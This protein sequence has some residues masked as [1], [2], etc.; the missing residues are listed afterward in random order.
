MATRTSTAPSNGPND[1]VLPQKKRAR[2][3]VVGAV[4]LALVA[5]IVLPLILDSE[6]RQVR[7]DVQV[8][9]PSRDT[10]LTERVDTAGRPPADAGDARAVSPADSA[11]ASIPPS[12]SA[13]PPS[14]PAT[15][16]A[17]A[18]GAAGASTASPASGAGALAAAAV[19]GGA[20]AVGASKAASASKT[21]STS[22]A[23]PAP[24]AESVPKAE[25]ASKAEAAPK[26][27]PAPKSES[28]PKPAATESKAAKVGG[29]HL[30]VGAFASEKAAQDQ[31]ERVRKIGGKSYT[32]RIKTQQGDRIR[33]RV[34]PYPTRE[35]A[36]QARAR[37]RAAGVE[38]AMVPHP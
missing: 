3:R 19:T 18:P 24:N 33:V 8:R 13:A 34:G 29:Y 22:K 10:P 12:D 28:T 38:A 37:L 2:R 31:A 9:I 27:E 35:A 7:D 30:Q 21:E 25:P 23:E 20:A 26:A 17:V 11:T 32:E 1:P 15:A 5:A 16:E 6:P 4:A 36:D 14:A